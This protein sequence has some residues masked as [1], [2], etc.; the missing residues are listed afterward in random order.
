MSD[1]NTATTRPITV[2]VTYVVR[3]V[4]GSPSVSRI[5]D[6]LSRQVVLCVVDGVSIVDLTATDAAVVVGD[7]GDLVESKDR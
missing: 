1:A 3:I 6:A 5:I 7:V 2:S 4:N